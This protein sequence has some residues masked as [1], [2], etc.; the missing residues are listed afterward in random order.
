[1]SVLALNDC[2]HKQKNSAFSGNGF[3]AT[4]NHTCVC[5]FL[6]ELMKVI[7]K[8]WMSTQKIEAALSQEG[9]PCSSKPFICLSQK[10]VSFIKEHMQWQFC[11]MCI[12]FS[13]ALKFSS[14]K[15]VLVF[16]S[17]LWYVSYHSGSLA[18]YLESGKPSY[19]TMYIKR[20]RKLLEWE[21][22]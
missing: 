6:F 19:W 18:V 7:T 10:E 1:M 8:S 5:T 15:S 11:K 16:V 22:P 12:Y 21:A 4:H 2:L 13:H 17:V 9:T 3:L 14:W 20:N